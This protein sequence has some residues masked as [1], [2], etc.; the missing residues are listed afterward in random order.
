M[1]TLAIPRTSSAVAEPSGRLG[2]MLFHQARAELLKLMRAPDFVAGAVLLPAVL[3]VL[4]GAR[5]IGTLLPDGTQ[6]GPFLVAAFTAY[7]LLGVVL[8]TFGESLAVERGQGWLRLARATP[9]PGAVFLAGKLAAGVTIGAVVIAVM[10]LT[11]T[12][13]GAGI[14]AGTWVGMGALGLAGALAL[15]PIGFLIGFLVRPTAASAVALLLYLPL[16]FA[17]GMWVPANELPDAVRAVAPYLP[18]YHF[19]QLVQSVIGGGALW[20]HVAWLAATFAVTG[21]LAVA[22]YRRM[23]G[24]QFA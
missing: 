20:D 9:L 18:T 23:V 19:A 6:L 12:V 10:A 16:S 3:F 22:A 21:T 14:D 17:S 24:R 11:S 1:T 2:G 8:F 7:G 5:A 15:A 4:F 13:L